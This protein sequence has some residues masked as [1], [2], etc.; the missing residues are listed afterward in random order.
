MAT[1]GSSAYRLDIYTEEQHSPNRY[2]FSLMEGG[3]RATRAHREAAPLFVTLIRMVAVFVVMFTVLGGVRVTLSVMTVQTLCEVSDTSNDLSQARMER[4]QL[5]A[6][7]SKL[8]ATDRIQRI[9]T[10]NYDMTF[11][12]SVDSITVRDE[13]LPEASVDATQSADDAEGEDG[14]A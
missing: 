14:V 10:D 2:D 1:L 3:G 8:M 6:D 11:A 5:Q 7:R 9:A 12:T 13:F 4:T